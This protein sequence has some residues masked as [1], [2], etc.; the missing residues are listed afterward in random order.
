MVLSKFDVGFDCC[1]NLFLSWRALIHANYL[2]SEVDWYFA[3]P[4]R[5]FCVLIEGD[6]NQDHGTVV[7]R[8][9]KHPLHVLISDGYCLKEETAGCVNK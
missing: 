7:V 3:T 5:T 2:Y 8:G 4:P 9:G 6:I 1:F